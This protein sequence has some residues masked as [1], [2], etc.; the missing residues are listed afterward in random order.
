MLVG[1]L[2]SPP[3]DEQVIQMMWDTSVWTEK[4]AFDWYHD[5]CVPGVSNL[6]SL[7]GRKTSTVILEV[8][9]RALES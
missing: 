4:S 8:Q 7:G 3:Y 5:S 2:E 9:I 6:R 1:R